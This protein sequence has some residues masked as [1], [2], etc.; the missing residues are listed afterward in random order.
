VTR[1][2]KN[3]LIAVVLLLAMTFQM[4]G[5]IRVKSATYDEQEYLARGYSV[6][7]TGDMRLR[8]RH[9]ILTNIISAAPLLLVPDLIMPTDHPSWISADF[10]AFSA[11]FLWNANRTHTDLIIYLCRWPMMLLTLVLAAFVCR[12]AGLL[13][14]EG[15]ALIALA[16]VA[17]DPNIIA[18]GRLANTDIG[19]TAFIFIAAFGFWAY[20]NQ[21][22]CPRLVA[23]GITCGLAQ[24]TRATALLLFPIF[25]LEALAVVWSTG[26]DS[27]WDNALRAALSLVVIVVLSLLTIWAVYGFTWG[28]VGGTGLSL[29]APDHWDEMI[30][31][32]QRLSRSDLAFLLGRI[33]RGGWWP[34]Y[35]VVFGIKTPLGTLALILVGLYLLIRSWESRRDL[36]LWLPVAAYF[37]SAILGNINTGYRMILPIV[38][39][40]AV[41]AARIAGFSATIERPGPRIRRDSACLFVM[42]TAVS[43]IGIYPHYLAYFNGIVQPDKGYRVVVDSNVDWGQDLPGLRDWMQ[44]REVDQV[45]LSWFGVAPPEHY[46][47]N[48]Q[49]LP[50]WPPFENEALRVY[51]PG[52]PLPGFYAISATNLQGV[53]LDDPDTFARFRSQQPVEEIGHSIMVYEIP[54]EGAP[55]NLALGHVRF[56]EIPAAILDRYFETNDLHLRWFNPETSLILMDGAINTES[57]YVLSADTSLASFFAENF[58]LQPRLVLTDPGLYLSPCPD[59]ITID[60][61]LSAAASSPVY[62]DLECMQGSENPMVQLPVQFGSVLNFIG[63]QLPSTPDDQSVTLVTY[64]RVQARPEGQLRIFV[65]LIDAQGNIVAQ[66]DGLDIPPEGW[67]RGDVLVQRH[68]LAIPKDRDTAGVYQLKVGLYDPE[69]LD[70]LQ[71]LDSTGT[72]LGSYILLGD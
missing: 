40:L 32:M 44:A 45:Y 25:A 58:A 41:H 47:V 12:W 26:E 55:D 67:Y 61:T 48:Y 4:M 6:L 35:P 59:R 64:W 33:Y 50:G 71:P 65:H 19:A 14:G 21:P 38:P 22:T 27:R 53:L 36:A 2:A 17:F 29:P 1:R 15:G 11:E 69:T 60:T 54:A 9:P 20:L 49:Y 34:Y 57:C 28:P 16:L 10:H 7:K 62:R 72:S 5:S 63:Y 46:G 3:L 70:R 56:D 51:H 8:L 66:Y 42:A 52:R 43:A 68:T 13:Y 37:G 24:T 18:H 30:A 31:L 39:F 23:A